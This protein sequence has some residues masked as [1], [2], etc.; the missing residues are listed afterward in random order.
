MEEI[1]FDIDKESKTVMPLLP[2]IDVNICGS[3]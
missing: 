2:E 3:R 1:G